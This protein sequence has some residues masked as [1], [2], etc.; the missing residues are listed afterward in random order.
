M[1]V[2]KSAGAAKAKEGSTVKKAA[3][4]KKAAAAAPKKAA[5]AAPKKAAA[6]APKKAAAAAPKLTPPQKIMLEKIGGH[7]DP[8]GYAGEKKEQKMI[9]A[10]LKHKVIKKGKKGE[11]GFHYL[12]SNAG[13]KV[14]STPSPASKS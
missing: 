11:K 7:A 9:E 12:I 10:L 1:A 4:P 2:K 8:V 3:A 14:L 5:A 13:K 6:A